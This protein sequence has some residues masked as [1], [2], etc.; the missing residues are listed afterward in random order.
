M[1]QD[2]K[3][4]FLSKEKLGQAEKGMTEGYRLHL[5]SDIIT[6]PTQPSHIT[7]DVNHLRAHR[8]TDHPVM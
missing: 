6:P 2:L 4:V 7:A 1:E 3:A 8:I 5:D